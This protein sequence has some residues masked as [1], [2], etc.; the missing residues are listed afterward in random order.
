MLPLRRNIAVGVQRLP[1]GPEPVNVAMMEEEDGVKGRHVERAHV[2]SSTGSIV[3]LIV[4][5][6]QTSV[7]TGI[8]V[9]KPAV[10]AESTKVFVRLGK[11]YLR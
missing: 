3:D 9:L 1:D 6:F 11:K 8:A 4:Q 2:A 10:V 5:I 7:L